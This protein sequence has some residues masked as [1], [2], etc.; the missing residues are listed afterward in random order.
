[1]YSPL[2]NPYAALSCGSYYSPYYRGGYYGGGG[3]VTIKVPKTGSLYG[4][5]VLAG[6][7]YARVRPAPAPQQSGGG[8]GRSG[9]RAVSRGLFG[10]DNGS[11]RGGSAGSS[12]SAKSSVSRSGFSKGGSSGGGAK[13]KGGGA[14]PKRS[15]KPKG[16]K[17]G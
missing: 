10:S 16:G 6:R 1:M 9:R 11:S 5:K 3:G 2:Y 13:P 4:G 7:G 15:A 8:I 12:G 17:D 14:K